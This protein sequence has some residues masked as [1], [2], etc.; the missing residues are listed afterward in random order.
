MLN[1]ELA[2]SGVVHTRLVSHVSSDL[3]TQYDTVVEFDTVAVVM[4]ATV[5]LGGG[6]SVSTIMMRERACTAYKLI[7]ARLGSVMPAGVV[8]EPKYGFENWI[9]WIFDVLR[10]DAVPQISVSCVGAI[11]AAPGTMSPNT[12]H[13]R[14]S[15]GA[16]VVVVTVVV[17]VVDAVFVV[18][19]VELGAVVVTTHAATEA[20]VTAA[21]V[22]GLA[23][24]MLG[25][26][27]VHKYVA[28][29][30]TMVDKEVLNH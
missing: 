24:V 29:A 27:V 16:S 28:S 18:V 14:A 7:V 19:V 9:V 23:Y 10:K 13:T 22:N 30:A 1:A 12:T 8:D 3:N 25:L 20:V 5:A 17:V 21:H 26:P 2:Q 4:S 11:A 15:D 6:K